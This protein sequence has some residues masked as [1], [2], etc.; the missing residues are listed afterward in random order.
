[1]FTSRAEH[2]LLLRV[3]NADLRLT[4]KGRE[5]G[6]VDDVRW[7]RFLARRDRFKKNFAQLATTSVRDCSGT[8]MGALQWLRQPQ[9]K[10]ETLSSSGAFTL[11]GPT[12][13]L[14]VASLET[15]VKYEGY[16]RRQEA[17]V[18]R[19][20][21]EEDRRI[22]ST[23]VY[24]TTPGLSR[25]VIQRLSQVQP[26]TLGQALRVPGVTPAAIAV[27]STYMRRSPAS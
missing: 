27:L 26:A 21:R 16:L 6:L 11:E 10:L 13:R 7:E 2:R 4:P 25:E 8:K 15:A 24:S 14:D 1:M 23:F 5:M 12:E 17:E 20:R 9:T 19:R 18:A 3:D 22:P